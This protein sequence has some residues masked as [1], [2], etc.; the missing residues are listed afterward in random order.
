MEFARCRPIYEEMPGWLEPT[1]AVRSF[2]ELPVRAKAYLKRLS[3][4]S[5]APV[6]WVSV[7]ARRDQTIEV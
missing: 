6:G 2:H 7:G 1:G 4:L 5:G 3:D